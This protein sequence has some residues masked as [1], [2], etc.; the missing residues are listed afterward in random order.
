MPAP[1]TKTGTCHAHSRSHSPPAA[2]FSIIELIVVITVVVILAAMTVPMFGGMTE[3]RLRRA[4]HELAM[5]LK[6]ARD[7]AVATRRHTWVDFDAA[8]EIYRVYIE[9]PSTPGRANRIW[10]PDP[11]T[12]S[13]QLQVTLNQGI[14]AGVTIT[15]ATF[16]TRTEVEFDRLGQPYDGL[17][18]LLLSDGT[19]LLAAG[20][21][22][23]TVRVVASTGFICQE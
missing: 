22:T 4:S 12:G 20:G 9:S 18:N 1:R 21:R 16:G 2:A 10:V 14:W 19:V 13:T 6:L 7:L 15:A 23:G 17:G 3:Q 8:N 5:H 11:V